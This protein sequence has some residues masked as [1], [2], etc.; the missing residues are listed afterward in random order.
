M[1]R[2][3][4]TEHPGWD[5][6]EGEAP[7]GKNQRQ[8]PR[9]RIHQAPVHKNVA[10]PFRLCDL[11]TTGF[12]FYTGENLASETRLKVSAG[13]VGENSA[14]VV[15]SHGLTHEGGWMPKDMRQQVH[16][17]FEMEY[18]AEA[19]ETLVKSIHAL[20]LNLAE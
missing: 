11:S 7:G 5:L 12:S 4:L 10:I 19:F 6:V 16:C 17:R 2:N 8:R 1:I 13:A 18:D 15:A 20:E 9:F 14:V 3:F